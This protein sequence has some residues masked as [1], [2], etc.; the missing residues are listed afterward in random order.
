M[1]S[2]ACSFQIL[3]SQL[4]IKQQQVSELESQATHLREVD[5]EKE[6]VISAK[7]A[8]VEERFRKVLAPLQWRRAQLDK[9]KKVHQFLRD[10][11]DEKLW[12][13]ERLPQAKSTDYGNSLLSVQMLQKKNQ[14]MKND[15][16]SHE[17]RINGVCDEGREMIADEHPQSE[18]FQQL[19]DEL[20]TLWQELIQATDERKERLKLSEVSQLVSTVICMYH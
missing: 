15:I 2:Y 10:M 9:V 14:A 20:M 3:E 5:P 12:I 7:A 11:E 16:D 4:K 18:E 1:L 17:P 13:E 6:Q 19:I 8:Q